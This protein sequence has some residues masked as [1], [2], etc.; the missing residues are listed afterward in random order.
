MLV[1]LFQNSRMNIMRSSSMLVKIRDFAIQK[2]KALLNMDFT[3]CY[4]SPWHNV[5]D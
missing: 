5:A 2:G 3:F 4:C 1:I